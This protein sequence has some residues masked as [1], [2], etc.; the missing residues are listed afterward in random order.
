M[1]EPE[2]ST[3]RVTD[4]RGSGAP[5]PEPVLADP[6][7]RRAVLL[8]RVGRVVGGLFL[9]WFFCLVLAGLGLLPTSG[10]PL[11]SSVAPRTQPQRL[12]RIP[13]PAPTPARDLQ[14]AQPLSSAERAPG[15][16]SSSP[17]G[18]STTKSG[19]PTT[20]TK[21]TSAPGKKPGKRVPAVT[22]NPSSSATTVP[23]PAA[24][25]PGKSTTAPGKSTT[26]P[27][28]ST[29]APGHAPV[30]PGNGNTT[31]TTTTTPGRSGSAPGQ[32][33]TDTTGHAPP[34]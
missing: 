19:R 12:S 16:A 24:S 13:A 1:S 26:T 8:H 6:S 32:T 4:L 34:K 29:T 7:G 18:T 15:G 33:R 23:A 17:S 2:R 20:T 22:T 10:V 5:V 9:L 11:A 28:K 25:A 27:G 3:I 30:K 31:T 21:H 14:P